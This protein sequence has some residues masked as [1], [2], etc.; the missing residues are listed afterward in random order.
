MKYILAVPEWGS[1]GGFLYVGPFPTREAAAEYGRCGPWAV[2]TVEDL[3][4]PEAQT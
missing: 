4:A 2:F 3:Q 1:N